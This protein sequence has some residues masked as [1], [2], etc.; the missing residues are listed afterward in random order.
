M[1]TIKTKDYC[2]FWI[3]DLEKN[4][5]WTGTDGYQLFNEDIVELDNNIPKLVS[6]TN[7]IVNIVGILQTSS[8]VKHGIDKR[9]HIIYIFRPIDK[10]LPEFLVASKLNNQLQNHWCVVDYLDWNITNKRP[11]GSIISILGFVGDYNVEK[12]ALYKHYRQVN[13]DHRT[14][15]TNYEKELKDI[16]NEYECDEWKLKRTNLTHLDTYSIDPI[17]CKDIDDAFSI[18]NDTLYIHI[19]DVTPWVKKESTIDKLAQMYFSTLYGDDI[20]FPMLPRELSENI[21]SLVLNKERACITL[22]IEFK[23]NKIIGHSL[24]QSII[25]NNHILNYDNCKEI[26]TTIK[27]FAEILGNII[28]INNVNDSHKVIE[29]FMIYYNM[30]IAG[31]DRCQLYRVQTKKEELFP[32]ELS[33]MNIESATYSLENKG[34][35][36]LG[37]PHYTHA[38]SP[39]RRYADILVQRMLRYEIIIADDLLLKLNQCQKNDR[40]FYRDLSFLNAIYNGNRVV[41]AIVLNNNYIYIKSWGQSLKYTNNYDV[42]SKISLEFYVDPNPIQWK[43]KIVFSK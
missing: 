2:N 11:R 6:R 25:K 39:I 34:H 13:I 1:L 4:I 29:I 35:Y 43:K 32:E 38:T 33:F 24:F 19:S 14:I 26:I 3:E 7:K 41:D 22:K 28:G 42:Y 17:G 31:L 40:K 15:K 5:V 27:P 21:C 9:G 18:D 12:N 23:E 8:K 36:Y 10:S 16:Q 30:Y 37:I 20:N